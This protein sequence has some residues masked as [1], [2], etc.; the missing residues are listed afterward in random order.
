MAA[1]LHNATRFLREMHEAEARG[2]IV[3]WANVVNLSEGAIN[4][5]GIQGA[6]AEHHRSSPHLASSGNSPKMTRKQRKEHYARKIEL[7]KK[8]EA[9]RRANWERRH[10][11]AA[12]SNW[13]RREAA[14]RTRRADRRKMRRL[15]HLMSSPS[16]SSNSSY[17]SSSRSSRSR[18]TSRS[19]SKK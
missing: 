6:I 1:P 10:P 14:Y 5:L 7:Y 3:P 8:G 13:E 17:R 12:E 4:E 11:G 18:K 2:Q 15:G 19:S 16:S 9:V